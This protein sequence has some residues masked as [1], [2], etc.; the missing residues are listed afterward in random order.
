[1]LSVQFALEVTAGPPI[2]ASTA[3]HSEISRADM[4]GKC[5]IYHTFFLAYSLRSYFPNIYQWHM[6]VGLIFHAYT[7]GICPNEPCALR[8]LDKTA[9]GA[10]DIRPPPSAPP[11]AF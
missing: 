10:H 9:S 3:R 2:Q 1:M 7:T 11:P 5:N 6:F 4:W 8:A